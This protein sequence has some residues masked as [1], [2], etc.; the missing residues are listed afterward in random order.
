MSPFMWRRACTAGTNCVEVAHLPAHAAMSDDV[1]TLIWDLVDPN[2]CTYDHRG[3]CQE[4]GWY[5]AGRVCPHA[6]AKTMLTWLDNEQER[7]T[8]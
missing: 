5:S 7:P 6:R 8:P 4:H 3:D 2:P 1:R